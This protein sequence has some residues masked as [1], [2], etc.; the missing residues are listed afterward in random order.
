[1]EKLFKIH[2]HDNVLIV[3]TPVEKGEMMRIGELQIRV[4]KSLSFGHKVAAQTIEKDE[5]VIKFGVPIGLATCTIAAGEHV[6]LH[7]L[8]SNYLP[9]YTLTH[10]FIK[11]D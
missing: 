8:K 2:P 6:H 10:E 9:T 3:R 11:K 7:N 5:Q 4:A 1:M